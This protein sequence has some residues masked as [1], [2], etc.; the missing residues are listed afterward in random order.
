M[1]VQGTIGSSSISLDNWLTIISLVIAVAGFL[2]AFLRYNK[3]IRRQRAEKALEAAD[4]FARDLL[5]AIVEISALWDTLGLP[6]LLDAALG[7]KQVYPLKFTASEYKK[8]CGDKRDIFIAARVAGVHPRYSDNE[9][10]NTLRKQINEYAESHGMTAI[11]RKNSQEKNWIT[12]NKLEAFAMIFTSNVGN[13][14]IVYS[15]LHKSYC[16]FIKYNYCYLCL[17]NV[18]TAPSARLYSNCIELYRLWIAET[19]K[20][21][22]KIKRQDARKDKKLKRIEEKAQTSKKKVEATDERKRDRA[23]T[24]PGM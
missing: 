7:G 1:G 12:M 5:P 20:K 8:T 18:S 4:V 15:S 9:L 13:H 14:K 23:S 24:P 6:E 16:D 22:R 11:E 17:C 10:D 2:T 3:E 21:D 19:E